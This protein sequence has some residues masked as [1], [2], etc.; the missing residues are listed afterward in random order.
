LEGW[1]GWVEPR[2]G[3]TRERVT[4]AGGGDARQWLGENGV[5]TSGVHECRVDLAA[6]LRDDKRCKQSVSTR[7]L[8]LAIPARQTRAMLQGR[9]YVTPDDVEHLSVPLFQHRLALVPGAG[10]P[11]AIIRD[12]MAGPIERLSRSTL[13]G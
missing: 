6:N 8:V 5:V 13:R 11:A 12:A 4:R 3:I 2:V 7:A 9:D 10:D 1:A